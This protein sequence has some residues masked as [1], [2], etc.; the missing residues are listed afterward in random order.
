[1]SVFS[2]VPFENG[3]LELNTC[4]EENLNSIMIFQNF[5]IQV[6]FSAKIGSVDLHILLEVAAPRVLQQVVTKLAVYKPRRVCSQ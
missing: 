4:S 6:T 2:H 1:M 5:L 3:M